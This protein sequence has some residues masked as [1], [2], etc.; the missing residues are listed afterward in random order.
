MII[1]D[2][3]G[4]SHICNSLHLA[5]S[6]RCSIA[7][8]QR[9]LN[10]ERSKMH[11]SMV[12]QWVKQFFTILKCFWDCWHTKS[13]PNHFPGCSILHTSQ[14]VQDFVHQWDKTLTHGQAPDRPLQPL[15]LAAP[16]SDAPRVDHQA[17]LELLME[18]I[19]PSTWWSTW[20]GESA[21]C[22]RVSSIGSI[23]Y[24]KWCRFS[25]NNISFNIRFWSDSLPLEINSQFSFSTS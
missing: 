3:S 9:V 5:Y 10:T 1:R 6:K 24:L 8:S 25:S 12:W 15:R 22:A 7:S 18:E 13:C 4:S 20:Y 23:I 11:G 14:V 17:E 2:P 16:S 19:Q 21:I